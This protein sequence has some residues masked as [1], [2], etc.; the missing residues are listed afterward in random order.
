MS[1]ELDDDHLQFQA[2]CRDFVTREVLPLVEKAEEDG[3]FPQSLWKPMAQAGLLGLSYPEEVGGTGGDMLAMAILAEELAKASGG[4][5]VTPLVSSYMASPH[6]HKFASPQLQE[7]WLRPALNGDKI[8]AIGVTEPDAGSDVAGMKTRAVKV[9]GGYKISG[10]KLFITNGGF[11][12]G[13]IVAARTNAEERHAGITMFLVEKESPGFTV[14]RALKKMGWHSSDTRELIF[15]DCFVPEDRIVGA[16]D[17]GFYQIANAF[18][19]ERVSLSGMGVGL[20]QACFDDALAYA[21]ERKT[22]GQ[23]IGK[24]QSIRHLLSEMSTKIELARLIT[25]QAAHR[26]D[27]DHPDAFTSVAQA[28]L[29][30][31]RIANEVADDAVQIFGG[32]GFIEE[33]RVALHYRDA[34]ILRIGGGTDEIMMEVLAKRFGL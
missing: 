19:G 33:T 11:A 31:A 16:V 12:D 18:Q 10:T 24:Y 8:M 1:F 7:E 4:I 6:L 30:S 23:A 5:A 9:D 26:L 21:K 34:R 25:Y 27:T 15:D 3:Q 17:R 20:A 13:I 32:Y 14:G 29:A 2:V 28:K 22:F